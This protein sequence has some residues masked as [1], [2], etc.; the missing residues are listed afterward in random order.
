MKVFRYI[1]SSK[2]V[3]GQFSLKTILNKIDVPTVC[4]DN[5]F[6]ISFVNK[7]AL[8]LWG[9]T[10]IAEIIDKKLSCLFL[11]EK[12]FTV[13][14]NHLNTKDSWKGRLIGLAK[15]NSSFD[16]E[17]SFNAFGIESQNVEWILTMKNISMPLRNKRLYKKYKSRFQNFL[18]SAPDAVL[19]VSE[20][21]II[22]MVN[23]KT[24]TLF[25]YNKEELL[26]QPV[27][28][29]IPHH[30]RKKHVNQRKNFNK[31]PHQRSMGSELNIYGLK[32]DGTKI[33]LDI[34]LGPIQE[35]RKGKVLVFARDI[36]KSKKA[37]DAIKSSLNEKEILLKEIH[38]RV[39]NNLAIV[40]SLLQLQAS[41]SKSQDLT[42]ALEEGINRIQSIASVHEQLYQE[43]LFS[44]IQL[45][46]YVQK[47]CKT[48]VSNYNDSE[49]EVDIN[50][51]CENIKLS[52]EKAVPV[53]LVLNE[54]ITNSFKYAL[55]DGKCNVWIT[56]RKIDDIIT[57]M[58]KDNGPGLPDQ[59]L[60]NNFNDSKGL[61]MTIIN[62]LSSQL[63]ADLTIE[64][65]PGATYI[66]EFGV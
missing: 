11:Q 29:L 63:E 18:R 27:E 30:H 52:M 50:I 7:E 55:Q 45:D 9:Y 31:T 65:T 2:N 32:K 15:N 23:P 49:R 34:M 35:D 44:S 16:I 6:N 57:F 61:G 36:T 66:F 21:G 33:P 42:N 38:H 17:A 20:E 1:N 22:E 3:S 10:D 12:K 64:N 25:A 53:G 41:Q 19:I 5:N 28:I 46:S 54:I 4:L 13:I 24:E 51:N 60:K 47:L 43:E 40:S 58:I 59:Y 62:V 48:L 39:K 8:K 14:Y 26:G 56:I 37:S